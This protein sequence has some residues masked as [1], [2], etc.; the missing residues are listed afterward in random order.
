MKFIPTWRLS[1]TSLQRRST[2]TNAV[3]VSD[4]DGAALDI[5]DLLNIELRCDNV[6]TFDTQ[7]DETIIAMQKQPSE[8]LVDDLYFRQLEESDQLKQLVALDIQD[9]VKKI[10]NTRVT[11]K[12][13]TGTCLYS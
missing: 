9:T 8:E 10:R 5:S 13:S 7:W 12:D 4:A 11:G 1:E 2:S 6:Q 3:A